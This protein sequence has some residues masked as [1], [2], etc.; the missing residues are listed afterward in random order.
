MTRAYLQ[1]KYG[2]TRLLPPEKLY[3]PLSEEEAEEYE[4][5]LQLS[6]K[7]FEEFF[8]DDGSEDID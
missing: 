3:E 7:A 5:G 1:E 6:K 4:K 2:I 8:D